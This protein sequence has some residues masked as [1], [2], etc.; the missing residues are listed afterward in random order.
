MLARG[1]ADALGRMPYL[2]SLDLRRTTLEFDDI[3]LLV[4]TII[5]CAARTPLALKLQGCLPTLRERH[6]CHAFGQLLAQ[7]RNCRNLTVDWKD[8][9]RSARMRIDMDRKDMDHKE[10]ISCLELLLMSLNTQSSH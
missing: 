10:A 6:H 1:L 3:K 4:P 2:G 5:S 9:E 8:V 7:L